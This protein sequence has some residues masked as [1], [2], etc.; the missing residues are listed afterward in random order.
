MTDY[1]TKYGTIHYGGFCEDDY[2]NITQYDQP[3]TG[4][5]PI[6]LQAPA[7]RAFQ[8]AEERVQS[9]RVRKLHAPRSSKNFRPIVCTG[10]WR[11][12]ALQAELYARDPNRYASPSGT[13]HT[14]GIAIDVSTALGSSFQRKVR[15]AL[16][17]VGWEQARP[18][19]PWHYSFGV[20]V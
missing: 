1:H 15:R 18:D 8:E 19:E 9:R 5:L 11:S 10:T 4:G 12:C 16:K 7:M 6:K 17:A 13:G 3:R 2:P 14:R 20:K